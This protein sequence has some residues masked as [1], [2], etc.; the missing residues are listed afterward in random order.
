MTVQVDILYSAR[1]LPRATSR[2]SSLSLTVFV[3]RADSP[4]WRLLKLLIM[5]QF[6]LKNKIV[7][8][9]A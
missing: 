5:S 3:T 2:N 9:V 4:D 7:F 8:L 6:Y 1:L